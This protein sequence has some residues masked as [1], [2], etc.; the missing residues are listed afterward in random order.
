LT[1]RSELADGEPDRTIGIVR[2]ILPAGAPISDL[3]ALKRAIDV[4]CHS[5]DEHAITLALAVLGVPD[6]SIQNVLARWQTAGRPNLE[7]FAPYTMHVFKVDLLYYLGIDR[8]FISGE[9]ASNKVDMAYLYYLPFSMLFTSGDNL[10]RRT[11][12]L[13]LREDQSFV[14][15]SA[16]KAALREL[17]AHYDQLSDEIK[18]LGVMVFAHYPPAELDNLVVELWDK[19]MRPDWRDG[20]ETPEQILARRASAPTEG[21]EVDEVRTRVETAQPVGNSE[22]QLEGEPDYVVLRRQMPV[23]RGK[24]RLLPEEVVNADGQAESP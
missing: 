14:E 4:F 22:T 24:W 12:P 20:A 9:R 11:A 5:G 19:H 15:A 18:A 17:D 6:H 7:A 23:H 21:H 8:G 16:F 1:W 13:F 10:H 3:G 2:N